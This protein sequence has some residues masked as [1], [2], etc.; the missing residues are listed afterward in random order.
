[1]L[2]VVPR[3]SV[4]VRR[5][6][7]KRGS[8]VALVA[9][10]M[11][12]C[13]WPVAA[14][15]QR[16]AA[17][18]QSQGGQ[19]TPPKSTAIVMGV[20]ID[21]SSNQPIAEA[22]VT[23]TQG[24]GGARGANAGALG[25]LGGNAANTA[26][27]AQAMQMLGMAGAGRGGNGPQRVMTG[28][29]GRFV[30]HG[31]PPGNYQLTV[32]LT[33]YTPS[34][35]VNVAGGGLA[36]IAMATF[37]PAGPPTS[38]QVKEGEIANNVKLRLWKN[39]VVTGSVRDDAGEPAIGL[40]V[41]VARRMMAGG[42]ARYVPAT[43]AKTDDRGAYRITGL[44]PGDYLIAVP[45][46][47]VSIPTA[48]MTGILDSLTSGNGVAGLMGSG[49]ALVDAMSSGINPTDAM[50]GGVRMG[51]FMVA[52]SGSVPLMTAD[53]RMQAYQTL[54]FPGAGAPA[55][56]TVVTLKSGEERGEINF[57]LSLIPTY[58]VSGIAM[59]PDGPLANLGV[60]LVVPGDGMI[61][62]SEFDVATAMTKA[63]GAFAF[64]GVPPGQFLLR[65]VK[66]PTPEMPAELLTNPSLG[67][68]FGA[69][70]KGSPEA[71]YGIVNIS[72]GGADLDNVVVQ[73]TPGFHVS[74]RVEFESATGRPQ[75]SA[76][77]L[78]NVTVTLTAMDG[79]SVAG[80]F[81]FGQ[82]DRTKAQGDF[83]T[84]GYAPGKYFLSVT[85]PAV[86]QPKTAVIGGRDVLDAPI[87]LK[88]ADLGGVVVTFTDKLPQLTGN[89]AS[90]GEAD[91]SEITVL[92]FPSN[93][94]SWVDNGMN[95]RRARTTRASR[96]GAFSFAN[97]P[98]GDYFVAAVDR[99]TE[100]DLQDPAYVEAVA[101]VAS[102]VTLGNDPAALDLT[103]VR[104]VIR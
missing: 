21:G 100:G 32:S 48:V 70:P 89:V 99:A 34:L 42:R 22:V 84:K 88:D 46:T 5:S 47:Q 53:G 56:A 43:S 82:P 50:A 69:F 91:L 58:R 79:R 33:G 60:R 101:R 11:A 7:V 30:F 103:K 57:Q 75:P 37:N 49:M 12:L 85:G 1:M 63:D 78:Q 54:F 17:P 16:G 76:T 20:V 23:L 83:K 9:L 45:Q 40:T 86:W 64:Y 94:R 41:Q 80:L 35:N 77:Q 61:S 24:G 18:P 73:M 25:A 102:R 44:V 62:E 10:G 104:V 13:C 4:R 59:G 19:T 36:G 38:L 97:L 68:M 81:D 29:D 15:A 65:A 87:E 27:M 93:Y 2:S 74:G 72:I 39:A 96:A 28:G 67:A 52:S 14:H 55:Q 3:T 95:P 71:L 98:P 26:Q 51:D 8:L 90:P 92:L 66:Q 31:L 6:A